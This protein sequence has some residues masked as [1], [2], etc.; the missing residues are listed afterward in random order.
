MKSLS[1]N[2]FHGKPCRTCGGTLRYVTAKAC[3]KCV[4]CSRAQGLTS[5]LPAHIP[6]DPSITDETTQPTFIAPRPC[7]RCGLRTR[8]VKS[9]RNCVRCKKQWRRDKE[10]ANPKYHSSIYKNCGITPEQYQQ[11]CEEQEWRC[12]ICKD[13]PKKLVGDHCHTKGNFRGLIC[14]HCN[15]GLGFF[16]DSPERMLSAIE[17]LRTC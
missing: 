5:K 4:A 6:V 14:S 11:M 2:K 8:Y 13:I 9:G 3:G 15:S 12:A 7:K 10:T 17:Y 16:K 1:D